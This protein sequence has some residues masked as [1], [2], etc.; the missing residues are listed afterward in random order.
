VP[1]IC[2]RASVPAFDGAI[3]RPLQ[4]STLAYTQ[5]AQTGAPPAWARAYALLAGCS[6]SE[7]KDRE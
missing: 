2:L 1:T 4:S 6:R 7:S 5:S 3:L